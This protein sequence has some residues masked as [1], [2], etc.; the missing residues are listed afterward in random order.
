[1][2][3]EHQHQAVKNV[4]QGDAANYRPENPV[5]RSKPAKPACNR[6]GS[7]LAKS[8]QNLLVCSHCGSITEV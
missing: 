3:Q 1:M 5:E 2:A 6:C 7:V 4:Q 8:G